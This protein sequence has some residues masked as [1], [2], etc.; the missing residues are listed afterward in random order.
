[1]EKILVQNL[2]KLP[3]TTYSL[4]KKIF[5]YGSSGTVPT[6]QAQGQVQ[7]PLPQKKKKKM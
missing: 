3:V 1:M 2:N 4:R 7:T 6:Y 5:L